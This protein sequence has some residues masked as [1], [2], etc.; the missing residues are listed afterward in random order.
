MFPTPKQI[1]AA[2]RALRRAYA[3]GCHQRFRI[4]DDRSGCVYGQYVNPQGEVYHVCDGGC[5]CPGGRKGL[6]CKH[7]VSLL[8]LTGR[9]DQ[10]IPG[11][12]ESDYDP[13]AA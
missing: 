11:V 6:I 4:V 9:L 7:L 2:K 8:D 10:L 1:E 3:E 5:D 12:Y 13:V